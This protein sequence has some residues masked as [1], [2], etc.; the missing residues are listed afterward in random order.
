MCDYTGCHSQSASG[1]F[2]STKPKIQ[3]NEENVQEGLVPK[4]LQPCE[5]EEKHQEGVFLPN[6]KIFHIFTVFE[7]E[8]VPIETFRMRLRRVKE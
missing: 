3:F 1:V 2:A 5:E 4:K 6:R 8:N 7:N